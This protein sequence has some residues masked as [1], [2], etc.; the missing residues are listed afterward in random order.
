MLRTHKPRRRLTAA[1]RME[2][3][4]EQLNRAR[5]S[6]SQMN[7]ALV[8]ASFAARGIDPET[9]TP[10][11][12]VLPFNAW[13]A[14]GRHVRRGEHGVKVPVVIV[15]AGS[16]SATDTPDSTETPNE[17]RKLFA[18]ATVFHVSQTEPDDSQNGSV[19]P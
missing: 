10:R 15:V 17:G 4:R 14:L 3:A 8:I 12:N 1:E 18:S 6:S 9:I 19:Q 2:L 5:A 16:D 7:D 13:R 11:I